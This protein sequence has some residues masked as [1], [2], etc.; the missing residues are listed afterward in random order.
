M[1]FN[2][3]TES[4]PAHTTPIYTTPTNTLLTYTTPTNTLPTYTTPTITSTTFTAHVYS[5]PTALSRSTFSSGSNERTTAQ[6]GKHSMSSGTTTVMSSTQ[7]SSLTTIVVIIVIIIIVI[8]AIIA[9]VILIVLFRQSLGKWILPS[10]LRHPSVRSKSNQHSREINGNLPNDIF[11]NPIPVATNGTQSSINLSEMHYVLDKSMKKNPEDGISES[12]NIITD[13]YAV[14]DESAPRDLIGI[15][16]SLDGPNAYAVRDQKGNQKANNKYETRTT[17]PNLSDM[18]AVVDK[19]AKIKANSPDEESISP[20]ISEMYAVVDKTAK[21]NA[22]E[23]IES[24][25]SPN[26]SDMYAVVDKKGNNNKALNEPSS[27]DFSEIY[28]VVK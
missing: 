27:Q 18:Y 7:N 10:T 15:Y 12:H 24:L 23:S 6:E 25:N 9:V 8:F 28:S 11:E 1:F 19:A 16:E 5:T 22:K 20:N 13:M 26:I 3:I 21:R 14:G 17:N 4:N 2:F